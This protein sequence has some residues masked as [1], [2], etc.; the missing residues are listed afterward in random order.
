M[1]ATAIWAGPGEV[2][3]GM[4]MEDKLDARFCVVAGAKG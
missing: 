3:A 1:P 4:L 2:L